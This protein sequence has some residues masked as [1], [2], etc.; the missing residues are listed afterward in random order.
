MSTLLSSKAGVVAVAAGT[1]AAI[2]AA[3]WFLLVKPKQGET[4]TLDASI[5][6]VERDIAVRRAELAR[7]KAEIRVRPSDLYRLSKA[8]PGVAGRRR[9]HARD[10][11]PRRPARDH[12]PLDQE[13]VARA[14]HQLHGP[15]VRGRP[16][17]TLREPLRLPR[18]SPQ[19]RARRRSSSSTS[20]VA[21]SPWTASSSPSP[22]A[23]RSSPRSRRPSRS[24]PSRSPALRLRPRPAR[25]PRPPRPPRRARRRAGRTQQERRPD[26]HQDPTPHRQSE[27][28]APADLHRDRRSRPAR[29]RLL[30]GPE[31]LEAAQPIRRPA[32]GPAGL[33]RSDRSDRRYDRDGSSRH[34]PRGLRRGRRA[35]PA[36]RCQDDG[37]RRRRVAVAGA[38]GD[39]GSALDVQPAAVEGPVRSAG[40]TRMPRSSRSR[41]SPAPSRRRGLAARRT[42]SPSRPRRARLRAPPSAPAELP[43]T[44]ATIEVNGNELRLKLDQRFPPA[45]KVFAA[46]RR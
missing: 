11:P 23:T 13:R 31:A 27:A 16:R 12:V 33:D 32:A 10:Q 17:G 26:G 5:T 25:P 1:A 21:C 41:R 8:L 34:R 6:V 36:A 28:A 30:P 44:Y 18:R 29:A 24:T 40:R 46:R 14:G 20:A 37:R 9:R 38:A 4:K 43:P 39:H 42:T 35:G 22:T 15:P 45:T 2:A 3:G 7:P 19:A